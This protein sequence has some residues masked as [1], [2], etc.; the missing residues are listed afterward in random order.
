VIAEIQR[1]GGLAVVAHPKDTAFDAIERFT[2]RP[3]GI[4][5]WNS[6]YD[7]RYAPRPATF[8][9]LG[10]MRRTDGSVQAFYGQDLH[11]RRQY[12]GL[13]TMLDVERCDREA[14]LAALKS[15]AYVGA[16]GDL[17]LPSNGVV[18]PMVLA[19]FE[20]HQARSRALRQTIRRARHWADSVGLV[21]PGGVKAQLRRIF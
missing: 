3:D 7:G 16:N 8:A 6:K 21:V 20:R 19:R 9:L 5:V 18:E 4:E 2:P 1:L 12:R 14:V 10:R 15:G 13:F 17:L 11:W